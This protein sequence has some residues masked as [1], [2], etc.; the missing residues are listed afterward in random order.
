MP[1]EQW[2]DARSVG[3]QS[4]VY[5][6][7]VAL[8]KLLTG[9]FPVEGDTA[10]QI[11]S[12]LMSGKKSRIRDFMPGIDKD[13]EHI[14]EKSVHLNVDQ[15]YQT[16]FDFGIR[17]SKYCIKNKLYHTIP[18]EFLRVTALRITKHIKN[19]PQS[20]STCPTLSTL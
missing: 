14:I 12:K 2:D 20:L 1:P 15:R 3:H 5:S 10:F 19:S 7:G 6:T 18:S 8:F 4:D 9:R 16:P 17:L 11:I 13:L